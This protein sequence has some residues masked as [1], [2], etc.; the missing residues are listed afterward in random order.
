MNRSKNQGL[1]S[2]SKLNV[3]I[4]WKM[5]AG[6]LLSALLPSILY[7][8]G[9]K[10]LPVLII[11][12]SV[13]LILALIA[14]YR[15]MG[16]LR[17]VQKN[18][19]A[20]EGDEADEKDELRLI[21]ESL[22]HFSEYFEKVQ[23][24]EC[25]ITHG[26]GSENSKVEKDYLGHLVTGEPIAGEIYVL[27]SRTSAEL[28]TSARLVGN[29]A[30]EVFFK[31]V[32][33]V[34]SDLEE[35][36]RLPG[37]SDDDKGIIEFQIIILNDPALIQ[38]MENSLSTGENL[39]G[40]LS[41]TFEAF[42]NKLKNSDN[43]YMKERI[44]DFTDLKQRL[45]DAIHE[46]YSQ[47]GV[48]R[49]SNCKGKIV[50]C[51]HVFP[52]EV[53]SIHKNGAIGII[54]KENT[55]SSHDQILLSSLNIPSISNIDDLPEKALGGHRAVLDVINGRLVIDPSDEEIKA[56]E[57]DFKNRKSEV[58]SESVTLKSGESIKIGVTVNNPGVEVS[59]ALEVCPDFVGLFRTEMH[60]IG[61]DRLPTE[62]ELTSVYQSLITSFKDKQVV[63]RML[64]LGA[65]KISGFQNEFTSEENPCMGRRSMRLLLDNPDLFR[66]QLRA[67]L[68]SAGD[69]VC[70][71]YP[72]I[73]GWSELQEIENFVKKTVDELNQEGLFVKDPKKGIMVEVPSIVTRFEDYVDHFE[74]FNIGTNDLTQYA[75][76]ADRNNEYVSRYYKSAHPSILAMISKVAGLCK[77][78]G[79]KAIICG[80]M[81]SDL[82]MLPLLIGL[83]I[84]NIS[85]NWA[86]VS[87]LK[88]EIQELEMEACLK[89]AESALACK[90]VEDVER[91]M[92]IS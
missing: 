71:L 68:K 84:E 1:M 35:M 13:S 85:V 8:S 30:I 77:E 80:Q 86:F 32:K 81:G 51:R 3:S 46:S 37:L 78:R 89:L 36:S 55:A 70:L 53:I 82:R 92:G 47:E 9:L 40:T 10:P 23:M 41:R 62:D 91:V 29:L 72:M 22:D 15:V 64:D 14:I 24:S 58:I 11:S 52:S 65:D 25:E 39:L 2:L 42:E 61:Q 12:L 38:E 83:G 66:L 16:T 69:N 79:K 26:F 17:R 75:L 21:N 31:A 73:S 90:S 19:A 88:K 33:K 63:V 34:I 74:V 27:P 56:V 43:A 18:L 7:M 76:A 59:H 49:F 87:Q 48:N 67:I 5:L 44:N 4:R 57:D 6:F 50:A 45:F 60:F 20:L 28:V 54:S